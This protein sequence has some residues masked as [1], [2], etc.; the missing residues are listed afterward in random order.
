MF[1]ILADKIIIIT[2][3]PSSYPDTIPMGPQTKKIGATFYALVGVHITILADYTTE[4]IS[5]EATVQWYYDNELIE[6]G[7]VTIME[8]GGKK[9]IL[10]C[11]YTPT[12]MGNNVCITGDKKQLIIPN[13]QL[14]HT[15]SYTLVVSG[16]TLTELFIRF[17]DTPCKLYHTCLT[18]GN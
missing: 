4:D 2:E 14:I 1:S 12:F 8:V 5:E 3:E 13:L 11:S 9:L 16:S 17:P 10:K 18:F 15:G 6:F 7:D